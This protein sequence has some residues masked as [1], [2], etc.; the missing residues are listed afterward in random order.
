MSDYFPNE[1]NPKPSPVLRTPSLTFICILTFVFSGLMFLSSLFCSL[2]Y[3][4]IPGLI[5]DSPYTKAFSSIEGWTETIKLMTQTNIWFFIFNTIL[6][7]VGLV[8]AYLMFRLRKIGFHF[9]TVAQILLLIIPMIYVAGYKTDFA[10][11]VITA[12]FI[13]LYY[14][15]LRIMK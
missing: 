4:Y 3:Y 10:T 6:Y 1:Q 7:G 13:F 14:T 5:E 11:T 2:Y 15:N 8:G 12:I 9:Y